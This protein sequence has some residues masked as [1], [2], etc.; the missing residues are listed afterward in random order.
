MFNKNM[1][2]VLVTSSVIVLTS[3]I[4][5]SAMEINQISSFQ[6]GKGEGYAEMIRYHSQSKSLLVTASE[7]GTIERISI[8]DPFNLKKLAPFDLSG[9]NITAV[10]VYKN[11]IAASIKEKIVDA[12][13]NVQ[14]F[15]DNGKKLAEYKTGA[16]PDNIAFSPDGRYLLTANEGEPSD[17]YKIDPEG[18]FTLIDLTNGTQNATVKQIMLNN[19]KLPAGARIVKPGSSFEEDAEPEYIAFSPDGKKAYATLQENNAIATID[20]ASAKVVSVSGLGFKNVSRISHDVSNKD[21]GINMKRWPVLMMYQPDAIVAYETKGSTYLVTANEGDAKDYDG[22]SE[23]TRVGKLK[24]DKTMFPNA[25]ELQKKENL[26]R[27]KTTKT[28]GDTDGDGDHDIIYAYGGRSFS[29]WKDDGT[30]VFD[31][32]NAFENIISKRS[33]EMFNAN[34]PS[35]IDDRSDDKGPEPEALAIGEI[36]GRIYAFIGMER[37][38][39]IFAYDIT[40]PSDPHM[41]SYIMPNEN[42]NSPEGLEFI[43]ANDSPTGKPLLAVAF[44]M[45]GT[46]GLYEINN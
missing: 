36:D 13:V 23:E 46:I 37:N 15:N 12:P 33:P 22:F 26:G 16:L 40:L 18:S 5:I 19:V 44:E 41:V 3:S 21:G 1:L 35:K 42:H 10:A 28:L 4:S 27:L 32:G 34:G 45:T 9:G 6:I 24:L 38:N 30:L 39:A 14:I 31:S 8:S 25:N 11:L 17:D 7:T 43:S 29:I 20:I 2:K